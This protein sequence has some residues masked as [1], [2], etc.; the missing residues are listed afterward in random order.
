MEKKFRKVQRLLNEIR[1]DLKKKGGVRAEMALQR[2]ANVEERLDN[3]WHILT[4][5]F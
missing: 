3:I 4:R 1:Q 2:L 5:K